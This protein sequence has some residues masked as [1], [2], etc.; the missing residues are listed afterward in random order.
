MAGSD[1]TLGCSFIVEL[2]DETVG[3]T[4]V[5]G[6]GIDPIDRS[7]DGGPDTARVTDVTLR[8]AVTADDTVWRWVQGAID[9]REC[10]DVTITL[11]DA[12]RRPVCAWLLR[13]SRPVA[14]RGPDLDALA[15]SVAIE[16]L[17]IRAT[18]IRLLPGRRHE[19]D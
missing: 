13:E 12:V 3:F 11:L 17:V 7:D 14:W 18:A 15:T 19:S 2:G 1:P 4:T 10:R 6:L 5:S 16:H 8:R 9:H